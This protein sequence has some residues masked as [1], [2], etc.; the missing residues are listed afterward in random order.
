MRL[1]DC[2]GGTCITYASILRCDRAAVRSLLPSAGSLD[3][4]KS[5]FGFGPIYSLLAFSVKAVGS[6]LLL[7][8]DRSRDCVYLSLGLRFSAELRR[9]ERDGGVGSLLAVDLSIK[10]I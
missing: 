6:N 2:I 4:D 10:F 7:K 5:G 1:T 9:A 8:T 3:R